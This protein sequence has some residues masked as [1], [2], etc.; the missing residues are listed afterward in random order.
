MPLSAA[1]KLLIRLRPII[2]WM[3]WYAPTA[4]PISGARAAAS[5]RL[6]RLV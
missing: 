4:F 1:A 5:E 6:F 3:I 2:P